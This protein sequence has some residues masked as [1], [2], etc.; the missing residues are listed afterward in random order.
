MT[1][2]HPYRILLVSNALGGGE[3]EDSPKKKSFCEAFCSQ[4]GLKQKKNNDKV[5]MINNKQLPV[6][7]KAYIL[8]GFL[9]LSKTGTNVGLS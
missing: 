1:L 9:W 2:L 8:L 3:G 5:I 4:N 7:V 6:L